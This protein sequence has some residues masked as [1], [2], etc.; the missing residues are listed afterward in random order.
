MNKYDLA[1][2]LVNLQ[3]LMQSQIATVTLASHTLDEEYERCF[4]QLKELIKNEAR[5]SNNDSPDK[6][7]TYLEGNIPG[8][9]QSPG[10]YP[11]PGDDG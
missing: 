10:K 11:G 4:H 7:R 8:R 6:D 3:T 9:G 1:M 5:K 2:Y